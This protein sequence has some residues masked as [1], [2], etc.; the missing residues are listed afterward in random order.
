MSK[1]RR[2]LLSMGAAALPLLAAPSLAS[3]Q[4]LLV[5]ASIR[6]PAR[7]RLPESEADVPRIYPRQLG[8][9]WFGL[10][11]ESAAPHGLWA[12]KGQDKGRSVPSH[13]SQIRALGFHAIRVPVSANTL[14]GVETPDWAQQVGYPKKSLSGL[15]YLLE[16][17]GKHGLKV[18]LVLSNFNPK[19]QSAGQAGKPYGPCSTCSNG[20]YTLNDWIGDLKLMAKVT[21]LYPNVVTGIEIWNE[22][23]KLDWSS[24]ARLAEKG[25]EAVLSVNDKLDILVDGVGGQ[26]KG[27][28]SHWGENF[29]DAVRDPVRLPKDRLVLA[30][31]T[32]SPQFIKSTHDYYKPGKGFPQTTP[33]YW[34]MF[35]GH[36]AK[37]GYRVQISEFAFGDRYGGRLSGRE[38]TWADLFFW[39]KRDRG[40]EEPSYF[41]SWNPNSDDT[42]GILENDWQSARADILSRL[43]PPA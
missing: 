21:T 11:T 8:V 23:H 16:Q 22:P 39:Y 15:G 37:A 12:P 13:M 26:H 18:L 32:Y 31:H 34:D 19:A 36:A 3:A 27:V 38:L 7:I 17:A 20:E 41:W 9:N 28:W 2:D 33:D 29:A 35:F 6:R 43:F 14:R 1:T 4:G 30:V 10:E 40:I 24:W 5:N 42:L 25:G